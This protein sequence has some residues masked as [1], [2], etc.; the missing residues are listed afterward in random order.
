MHFLQRCFVLLCL[1]ILP[2]GCTGVPEGIEPVKDFDVERYLGTWHEIARLDHSFERGLT[3]V[4]ANYSPRKDSGIRVVNRGFD[5]E[6]NS[7][8]EAE[9]KAYFTQAPDIGTL[10]VSFFGPFYGAY[11]IFSLDHENYQWAMICGNNTDYLWI[12]A[13]DTEIDKQVLEE[14]LSLAKSKGFAT[15]ELIYPQR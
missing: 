8:S 5:V 15:D 13:R 9:G 11:N 14:L 7:W 3:K 6:D 10:K 2:A 12:L 4:T 1:V